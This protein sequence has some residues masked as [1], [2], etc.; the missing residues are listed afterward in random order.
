[1][2]NKRGISSNIIVDTTDT[3]YIIELLGNSMAYNLHNGLGCVT[4]H[5]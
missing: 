2:V 1:M 5:G 4:A 3:T